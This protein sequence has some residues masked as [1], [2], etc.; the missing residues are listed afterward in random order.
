V[1]KK[2]PTCRGSGSR[3]RRRAGDGLHVALQAAD[4]NPANNALGNL[5]DVSMA[6]N[7]HNVRRARKDSSSGAMGAQKH[8]PGKWQ[9]RIL[10]DGERRSLGVFDTPEAARDAYLAAKRQHHSGFAG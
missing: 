8:R 5:R 3:C 6:I 7:T 10:V 1:A 4:G 9:A 2:S